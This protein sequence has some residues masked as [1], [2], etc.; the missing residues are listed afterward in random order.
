MNSPFRSKMVG[1]GHCLRATRSVKNGGL[2]TL[3][4]SHPFSQ[5]WWIMDTVFEPPVQSKV[6]VY[7]TVFE[8]PVPSKV[9]VYG[10]SLSHLFLQKWWLM[11]QV[12]EPP[13]PLKVVVY[14]H[15]SSHPFLLKW[16]FLDGLHSCDQASSSQVTGRPNLV[17]AVVSGNR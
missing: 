13:V 9:V 15:S 14:V 5:K 12:F 2:W 10:H 1:Y 4:L 11:D 16:W 3:S 8:S 17:H 6:V 7:G